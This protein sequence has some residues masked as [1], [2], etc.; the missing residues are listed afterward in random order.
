MTMLDRIKIPAAFWLGVDR[1]KIRRSELLRVARLPV[2]SGHEDSHVTT[3][4]F[5]ALWRGLETL[6][7]ADAG[8]D[9]ARALDRDVMPPSFLVGFH[10]K[11]LEDALQRVARFKSLCA[12]EELQITTQTKQCV[13]SVSWPF[14]KEAAP[15]ALIDATMVALVDLARL[16]TGEDVQP[17][18][19]ELRREKS[20]ALKAHCRCPIF[21]KAVQDR[22]ILRQ[23]DLC[24]PFQS[25]NREL[26]DI[27]DTALSTAANA[28]RSSV[29]LPDQVRWLIRRHLTAGRP[30]IQ[31][32]AHELSVS[33]RSLQRRLS[34]E[35]HSFQ[36]L[37]SETRHAMACEYLGLNTLDLAEIAFMLGY[38]DQGSFFRAFQK[39]EGRTP[40][41]WREANLTAPITSTLQH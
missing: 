26:L 13:V 20:A 36:S 9:L 10:A 2:Q 24:L 31:C 35:G 25:Y 14:G 33:E 23:S 22:L 41:Q 11:D 34:E 39:W 29:T 6:H 12:P 8:L 40:S 37:L 28:R 17:V 5:F 18:R 15:P 30:E 19:L 27:L 3:A 4:Q 1:L 21:W 32:V 38:E 16:G 7:G